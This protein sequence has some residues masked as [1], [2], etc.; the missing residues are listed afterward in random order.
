MNKT[1]LMQSNDV[2]CEI[3]S[4]SRIFFGIKL[5]NDLSETIINSVKTHYFLLSSE[6]VA[7]THL[8]LYS[9]LTK[10]IELGFFLYPS[11]VFMCVANLFSFQNSVYG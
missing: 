7:S 11:L 2:L 10:T 1:V 5:C 9:G 3:N 4:I 8:K 6:W